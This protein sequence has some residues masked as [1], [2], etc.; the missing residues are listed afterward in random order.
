MPSAE[1]NYWAILVG[2][3]SNMLIGYVWY[4]RPVLG[5]T[6]MGLI[7]KTE[8][9]LKAKAGPAMGLMVLLALL[10]SYVMAH[11]VDYT[12]SKTFMDGATTGIWVWL[13]FVFTEM[14]A[15]N[16]FAQRPFKLSMITSG[17]QLVSLVVMGGILATWK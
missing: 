15:T 17:Y 2:A 5:N 11:F 13:G 7:G 9:Q 3:A 4:A 12:N 14:V 16:L 6:W 10:T 1:L 8:E